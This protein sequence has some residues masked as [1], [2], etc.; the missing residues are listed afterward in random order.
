[1]KFYHLDRGNSLKE[2]QVVELK[3]IDDIECTN[4]P[5]LSSELQN[6]FNELFSDGVTR[7][8]EMYFAFGGHN[9]SNPI[10]EL[11]LEYIRKA[12]F[13]NKP[14]RNK[15]LFAVENINDIF[16]LATLLNAKNF[17]V[18]EVECESYFKANMNLLGINTPSILINSYIFN[19][20]WKGNQ[21]IDDNPLWEYLL[22]P[23]VKIIRKI[24][25]D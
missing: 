6:H 11:I 20:Y 10:I 19:D 12:N 2:G 3:Q 9:N 15:C 8:G 18:W 5:K 14:S 25:L 4:V 22:V 16:R 7:H 17:T 13:N 23:P 21:G 24:E 1:M